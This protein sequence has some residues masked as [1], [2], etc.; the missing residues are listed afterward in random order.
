M[1]REGRGWRVLDAGRSGVGRE[2]RAAGTPGED[3]KSG[4]AACGLERSERELAGVACGL[5]RRGAEDLGLNVIA[6]AG[7]W[8]GRHLV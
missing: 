5:A 6:S 8:A 3:G 7:F 4:W 2:D 1:G